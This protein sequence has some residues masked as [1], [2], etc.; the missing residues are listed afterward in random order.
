MNMTRKE[1]TLQLQKAI[2]NYNKY[3]DLYNKTC[4]ECLRA[5]MVENNREKEKEL[6]AKCDDLFDNYV[7]PNFRLAIEL[8]QELLNITEGQAI[9]VLHS[10]K[11]KEIMKLTII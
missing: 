4:T 8:L 2:R 6:D 11:T 7:E 3:N 10:P 5:C 9:G 1:K